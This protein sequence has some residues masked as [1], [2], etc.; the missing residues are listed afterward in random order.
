MHKM[1]A[2]TLIK[3]KKLP[4][5]LNDIF[6]RNDL[7]LRDTTVNMVMAFGQKVRMMNIRSRAKSSP[8]VI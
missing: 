5:E 8:A 3:E 7:D 2:D 4:P 1:Q 6:V